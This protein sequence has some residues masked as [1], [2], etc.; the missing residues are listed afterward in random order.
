MSTLPLASFEYLYMDNMSAHAGA[1]DGVDA[2]Y[3]FHN[4]PTLPLGAIGGS[5]ATLMAGTS[6]FNIT[7]HGR[8]GHA[9]IPHGNIDPILPAA[10][11]VTAV[12]VRR[13]V[14]CHAFARL[15]RANPSGRALH[16]CGAG[17]SSCR[18][19]AAS[20]VHGCAGEFG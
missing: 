1:L 10:H 12:Q 19:P 17:A 9:A 11:F 6:T 3:G 15:H 18:R 14:A 4:M 2:I 16:V 20:C 5:P 7:F 8:G 13:C